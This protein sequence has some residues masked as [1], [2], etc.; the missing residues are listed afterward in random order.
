LNNVT[1]YSRYGP[2]SQVAVTAPGGALE[3]SSGT[4]QCG[5]TQLRG[6][7]PSTVPGV[8]SGSFSYGLAS[9]TSLAAAH[10]SGVVALAL[11][12]QPGLSFNDVVT[13]LQANAD[14]N[15]CYL[16]VRQGAGLIDAA[17]LMQPLQ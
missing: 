1:K 2:G 7:L 11:Q 13:Q 10:A 15:N 14:F 8:P 5:N 9:G 12:C 3:S 16:A 4:P 6:R 17:Q